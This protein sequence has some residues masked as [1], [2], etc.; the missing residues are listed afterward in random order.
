MKINGTYQL[1]SSAL[2]DFKRDKIRTGLTSLGIMIGVLSVVMLIALGLGLKNYI[3]QQFENLGANLVMILPGSGFSGG[4][5]AGLAGGTEFDEKDIRS[6]QKIDNLK[7]VVPVYF[8]SITISS[9]NEEKTGYVMGANEQIFE[10]MNVNTVAGKLWTK[11][12]LGNRAKVAVLGFTK[13]EELYGK[14]E[15]ALGK[16]IRIESMRLKVV[17]IA[18]KTGDR[19]QDN[20]A[21]IPYTTT[22]GSMNPKKT[23]WAIYLGIP[24]EKYV[25][26]VK[27]DVEKTL[28]KRYDK[29]KFSVTEQSEI[30]STVNQIFGIINLV[31]I[32]IGSISLIVGGIGIMNI[33]Y[34][35]VTERT[36]EVG[37][38]RALGATKKDILF[39][40]LTESTLLS[41]FGGVVG[42]FLAIGIVAIVRN[43]FP[44][45]INLFAVILAL[46]V[47]SGI[48][49][50]FGVFPAKKAA[51]L[52]PMEAIRYE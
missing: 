51:D 4:G 37:I 52:S 24:E 22:F 41:L 44:V 48:G 29:D 49:I 7:Y 30:L 13:A 21:F 42:L 6:I 25:A 43:W 20:A 47:S 33:M 46:G 19:E 8:R 39:Q 35:T 2:A 14:A 28:T 50:F 10:L 15:D 26:G 45:A 11:T 27:E 12:D 40:F 31:L 36:R 18:K 23:F 17:G 38:R 16:T 1:L 3:Q 5:P 9:A 32:A 34:A